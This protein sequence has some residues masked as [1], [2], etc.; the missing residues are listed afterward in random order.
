MTE[1]ELSDTVIDRKK[2]RDTLF[3]EGQTRNCVS[4]RLV[5]VVFPRAWSDGRWIYMVFPG[6]VATVG[7]SWLGR[8]GVAPTMKAAQQEADHQ[9]ML[10]DWETL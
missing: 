6:Q 3:A 9:L 5:G 4:G 8:K 10:F 1:F 7:K 2:Q